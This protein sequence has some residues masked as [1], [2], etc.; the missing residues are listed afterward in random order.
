VKIDQLE[1]I[2]FAEDAE[3]SLVDLNNWIFGISIGI[4]AIL[5]FKFLLPKLH[6]IFS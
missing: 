3:K 6:P 5:I 1:K 4:Y 2:K